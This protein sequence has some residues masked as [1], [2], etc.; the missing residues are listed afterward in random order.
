MKNLLLLLALVSMLTSCAYIEGYNKPQEELYINIT[1]PHTKDIN[2]NEKGEL[3]KDIK[4]QNYYDVEVSG[5]AL[6]NCDV[7][8]YG[9]VKI[10]RS[11]MNKIFIGNARDWD[12]VRIDCRQGIGNGKTGE[13]HDLEIK[14]FS[15]EKTYHTKTQVEHQ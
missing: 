1:S 7:I 3:P 12:I 11:G 13:K 6:E 10:K 4:D 14:V 2:F 8:D 15:D 9:D 5:S